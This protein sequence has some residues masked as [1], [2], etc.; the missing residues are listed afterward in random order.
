MKLTSLSVAK[1]LVFTV[2][3]VVALSGIGFGI[4]IHSLYNVERMLKSESSEHIS[5]LT[6]NSIITR[7]VFELTTRVQ[8]LEQAILYSESALSEEGFNI[9]QQLQKMRE[10]SS[11]PVFAK[12]MDNFIDNFHRFLGNSL[13]L[14]RIIKETHDT[15]VLLEMALNKLDFLVAD[16][17][18]KRLF[19]GHTEHENTNLD[20]ITML[21]ESFLT[22]GKRV[23]T[24]RSRIT[25]ETEKVVIIEVQK[26]LDIFLL[27]LTN[28]ESD[29][30]AVIAQKRQVRRAAMKLNAALR[31]MQANLDQR[32]TVIAALVKS[33]NELLTLVQNT[34]EKVQDSAVKLTQNMEDDITN[35]RSDAFIIA[36]LA[37]FSGFF[38]VSRLVKKHIRQ[39]LD[40]LSEGFQRL[41]SSSFHRQ[42]HLGRSDEWSQ[43]EN[44]FN[45]MAS[46]LEETYSQL[47]DEKR[48]FDFLAHHDPLTGLANR[49]L[50]VQQLEELIEK[51]Y[52]NHTPFVLLYLDVDQFKLVN[53]SLG[54]AIGDQLLIDVSDVLRSIIGDQGTV[55]RM[56]GDEFMIILSQVRDIAS[57]TI[58]AS[59]LNKALRRPYFLDG[60]T[61]FVSSSIGLCQYPK[62][63]KDGETLIRNADTA[64]YQAKRCGR[65]QYCVYTDSM[66]LEANDLIEISSGLRQAIELEQFEIVFQPRM[67]LR[68]NKILGAEALVRWNHPE[69]GV[70]EPMDFLNIAEKSELIVEIDNWVLNKIVAFIA[71]WKTHGFVIDDLIFSVNFSAR[72]FF[73]ETLVSELD[74]MFKLSG[75]SPTQ[76]ELEITE[77]DMMS[78]FE[79]SARTIETLRQKGFSIAIDDFGTGHSSLALL[80]KLSVD[81]VK[82]DR[83]FI[84][85]INRSERDL[86]IVNAIV[87][88]ACQLNFNVIAEGVETTEQIKQLLDI[89][90]YYAQGYHFAHPLSETEW[91]DVMM[92]RSV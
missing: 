45:K 89:D 83:S 41:E 47:I 24:V 4:V 72:K 15:D 54:H 12:K 33:Q 68:N 23:G 6:V 64:M 9:D 78:G 58:I 79:R 28:L 80:K 31:K 48:N 66:T 17:K 36:C 53:D 1:R 85:D 14:N 2:G 34:E 62:H 61:V 42:I 69:Y 8:L 60:K 40:S 18:V 55:A 39:P 7:Q 65:D 77:R 82:L 75:C 22:V 91:E 38:L 59:Q 11:N 44:A 81:T 35:S 86:I 63:A 32:W 56:G 51:S 46:R 50:A 70:L 16:S 84:Q 25:P 92:Q 76:F 13:T 67:D 43:I 19:S 87:N 21:R 10:L 49:L 90:C 30:Q 74:E 73:A 3:I 5:L 57:G 37:I 27:H 88:L 20:I 52:L 26:E 29:D 71:R